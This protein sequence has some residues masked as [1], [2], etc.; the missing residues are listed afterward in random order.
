[1]TV[2]DGRAHVAPNHVMETF[3][4]DAALLDTVA[5]FLAPALSSRDAIVAIAT[6]PHLQA[7]ERR[8]G[9]A[10]DLTT[11]RSEGR[12]L[13]LD[14]DATLTQVMVEGRPDR[15]RFMRAV[16]APIAEALRRHGGVRAFGE[17][18]SLLWGRGESSGAIAL[19]MLWNDL[20]GAHPVALLCG[21]TTSGSEDLGAVYGQHARVPAGSRRLT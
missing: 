2:D 7:L 5:P 17:M 14:A 12:F 3:E 8:L 11:A 16:G 6:P 20:I 21:Y 18:V 9:G 10:H 1:M 19:E 4:S 15:Q 13:T